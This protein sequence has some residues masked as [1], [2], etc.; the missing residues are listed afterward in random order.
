MGKYLSAAGKARR[1]VL[2]RGSLYLHIRRCRP[3]PGQY[4]P[5]WPERFPSF[6]EY[7]DTPSL[8]IDMRGLLTRCADLHAAYVYMW[9]GIHTPFYVYR[10]AFAVVVS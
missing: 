9:D 10:R 4:I 5:T 1:Q 6:F 7:L 3:S 2:L 8:R